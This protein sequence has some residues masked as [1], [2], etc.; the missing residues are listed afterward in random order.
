MLSLANGLG[1][2]IGDII[3]LIPRY[4]DNTDAVHRALQFTFQTRLFKVKV[5]A[6]VVVHASSQ[7]VFHYFCLHSE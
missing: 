6:V 7:P 1:K 5:N 2:S 4:G 3:D